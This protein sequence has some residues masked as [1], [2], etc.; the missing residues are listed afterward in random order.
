MQ[1]LKQR[2]RRD[3]AYSDLFPRL[4][5]SF[6][7]SQDPLPRGGST[8]SERRALLYQSLS[9]KC[10]PRPQTCFQATSLIEMFS[11][12]L[13]SSQMTPSLC[14]VEDTH[15]FQHTARRDLTTV[16]HRT[17]V[18]KLRNGH[19]LKRTPVQEAAVS[20]GPGERQQEGHRH[21]D[22]ALLPLIALG[23]HGSVAAN[24]HFMQT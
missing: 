16:L 17:K 8:Q 13:S 18:D 24:T 20:R 10:S 6:C 4:T 15:I 3:V 9:R 1:E 12:L 19:S 5:L 14:Q 23:H 22:L 11:Q 2:P 7:T 21:L